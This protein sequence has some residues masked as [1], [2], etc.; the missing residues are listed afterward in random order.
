MDEAKAG[1]VLF[2]FLAE[3][4][5]TDDYRRHLGIVSLIRRDLAQL[6]RLVGVSPDGEAPPK[7][8][9]A[10]VDGIVL[11]IDDLDRCPP[12]RVVEVLEAV[13]LLLGM[14]L[15]VVVVAVDS[16]WL[17]RSL[18]EHYGKLLPLERSH[19]GE[20]VAVRLTT[21]RQFLEKVFQIPFAVRS[22]D[23]TLFAGVVRALLPL[24][25]DADTGRSA[26]ADRGRSSPA[27]ASDGGGPGTAVATGQGAG[28]GGPGTAVATGQGA[29][30]ASLLP[31][32][33]WIPRVRRFSFEPWVESLSAE[34]PPSGL[35]AGEARTPRSESGPSM[36]G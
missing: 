3:R 33:A 20:S 17:V 4:A 32:R 7:E 26:T 13:H 27:R 29:G 21:P 30:G 15:F 5:Q 31:F 16:R 28:G 14:R 10:Q 25:A 22:L 6:S 2:R 23:P 1:R 35:R 18:Y 11:Y 34:L 12:G 8:L 19:R 24:E 36:H 9:V